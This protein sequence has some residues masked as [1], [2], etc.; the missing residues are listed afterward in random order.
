[1]AITVI[2]SVPE[3]IGIA[4]KAPE[5]ATWSSLIAVCGLHDRPKRKSKKGICSKN[6]IASKI[7]ENTMPIV[8]SMAIVEQNIRSLI[9]TL[10]T[11]CLALNLDEIFLSVKLLPIKPKDKIAI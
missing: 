6:R 7:N 1:M 9:F 8:V 4:P 5:L 3:K 2:N 10:S 11:D